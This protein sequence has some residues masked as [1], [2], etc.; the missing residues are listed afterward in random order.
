[1]FIFISSSNFS[2]FILFSIIFFHVLSSFSIEILS[3][4]NFLTHIFSKTSKFA[5]LSRFILV[6]VS[7]QVFGVGKL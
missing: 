1:M 6:K 3:N 2:N 4:L 5:K 7:I